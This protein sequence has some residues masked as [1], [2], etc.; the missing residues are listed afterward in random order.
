MKAQTT[1]AIS[2]LVL[3]FAASA[4]VAQDYGDGKAKAPPVPAM[5][6]PLTAEQQ[7]ALRA[8]EARIAGVETLA[9]KIDDAAQRAG[10][11]AAVA[12]LH[13]RRAALEKNFDSGL[14]EALM[15]AVISRYQLT[16]LWLTPPREPGAAPAGE[17]AAAGR[18]TVPGL[19][20]TLVKVGRGTFVMGHEEGYPG[21]S[22][23]EK[24]ATRV[25]FTKDFWLGATEVSV[26]QWRYFV[27][28]TGY[29]TEAEV[30][31]AGIYFKKTENKRPGFNW[32][33]PGHEQ[34]DRHPVV[35]ISWSDAKQFCNW[36]TEREGSAGRLPAGHVYTLPTEAQWEYACRAGRA[37]D[38]ENADDVSWYAPNSGGVPH[39]VG[40]KRANPWGLH[41]M[42]GNV[43]EWVHDWYGRYPGGSVTDPTGPAT[44]NDSEV[45]RPHREMRGGGARDLAGHGIMS[46]NRWSTWGVTQST[47]VGLRVALSASL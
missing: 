12:D 27:E 38:P 39:P 37:D 40:T 16:A 19:D 45:I 32:R 31:N 41:D 35:G 34:T 8:V 26:G 43:W 24:P 15:H 36:L 25:T 3:A 13:K 6:V 30:G 7:T 28:T 47:W 17:S 1:L 20:L 5:S 18:K 46:T 23:D 2:A 44:A 22:R 11:A 29:V 4:L 9:A 21:S 10:V 33:N 42:Q 14:Y